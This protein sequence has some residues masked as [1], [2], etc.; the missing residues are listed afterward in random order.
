MSGTPPAVTLYL[1]RHGAV[2]GVDGWC[3][4]QSD[5]ALAVDGRTAVER[6][7]AEWTAPRPPR[8][9]ASDLARARDSAEAL[10]RA[11]HGDGIHVATDPRLREMHFGAWDGRAWDEIARD[12][13]HALA[14][15][16]SCWQEARSPGGEGFGDVI[17]RAG[18]WLADAVRDARA[19]GISSLTA[20][21]HAGSIRA[22]LVHALGLP[23]AVVF[24]L[25]VDHARVSALRVTGDVT[26]DA[27]EAAELL[28][29]NA[30]RASDG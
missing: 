10:A 12:D 2:D 16:M 29:L 19:D 17:A 15:W 28:V 21:A 27:C 26:R 7:A 14:E 3:V 22:L 13:P 30:D 23:R 18:A 6:L 24:R 8:I 5:V 1:V 11:W 20:V 4:G 25:R 9:V